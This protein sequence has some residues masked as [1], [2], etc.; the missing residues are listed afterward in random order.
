MIK[1]LFKS[2]HKTNIIFSNPSS[3]RASLSMSRT[4]VEER[5][6]CPSHYCCISHE[7]F[8]SASQ[9]PNKIAVIHA[10]GG[11]QLCQDLSERRLV[12]SDDAVVEEW[13]RKCRES[14]SPSLYKGD[15]GFTYGE[16]LASV[17]SLSRRIRQIL[18][19]ED[20]IRPG[21]LYY[22]NFIFYY[23]AI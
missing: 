6:F 15:L 12:Y 16:I 17:D 5:P 22:K 11:L 2:P 8:K 18:D 21:G 14:S 1:N 19:D 10:T 20:L 3:T 23:L 7:F 13:C 9:N 4:T